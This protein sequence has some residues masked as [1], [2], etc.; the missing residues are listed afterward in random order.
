[1][2]SVARKSLF[3][4]KNTQTVAGRKTFRNLHKRKSALRRVWDGKGFGNFESET[5]MGAV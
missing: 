3:N 1:V 5:K 4:A 2:E